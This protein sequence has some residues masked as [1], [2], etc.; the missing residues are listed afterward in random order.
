MCSGSVF[1]SQRVTSFPTGKKFEIKYSHLICD[2]KYFTLLSHT[3][4]FSSLFEFC[5]SERRNATGEA[6]S[7]DQREAATEEEQASKGNLVENRTVIFKI[8]NK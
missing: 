8:F 2:L 6:E 1:T 5:R 7:Q 4:H 3:V